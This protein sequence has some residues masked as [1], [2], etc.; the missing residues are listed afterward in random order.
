MWVSEVE[1]NYFILIQNIS[2]T[3]FPYLRGDDALDIMPI[4]VCRR[5]GEGVYSLVACLC[6]LTIDHASLSRGGEEGGVL[7]LCMATVV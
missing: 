5:G 3:Q 2:I 1:N 6:H 7:S 4:D